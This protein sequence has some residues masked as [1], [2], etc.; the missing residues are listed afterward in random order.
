MTVIDAQII[1]LTFNDVDID[2]NKVER[3]SHK[4]HFLPRVEM[5]NY[6]KL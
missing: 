4:K 6:I 1:V 3:S 5:N 2:A